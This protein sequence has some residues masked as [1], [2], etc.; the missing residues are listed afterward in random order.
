MLAAQ[1]AS[2]LAAALLA[3]NAA[4]CGQPAVQP[5]RVTVATAEPQASSSDSPTPANSPV[6]NAVPLDAKPHRAGIAKLDGCFDAELTGSPPH[7]LICR[8]P[9]AHTPLELRRRHDGEPCCRQPITVVVNSGGRVLLTRDACSFVPPDCAHAHG[10]GDM[11]AHVRI[12]DGSPPTLLVVEGGCEMRA[13]MHG[14][15]PPGVAAW[16][17]CNR[18]TYRWDGVA[19]VRQ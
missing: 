19:L 15:V 9:R 10:H 11:D 17:G 4:S 13:T 12:L 5:S 8:R 3:A 7:E 6:P 1:S 16:S 14:Y 2:A 18:E